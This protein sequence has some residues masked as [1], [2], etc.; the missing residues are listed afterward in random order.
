M[1]IQTTIEIERTDYDGNVI[2]VFTA[3]VEG[4]YS[5]AC[6]GSRDHYG[7]QMEPDTEADIDFV[8]VTD[9]NGEELNLCQDDQQRALDALWE[10]VSDHH[11]N[12]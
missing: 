3:D 9:A 6:K 2:D 7:Q 10:A 1:K 8:I 11:D 5:P 12:D 4:E